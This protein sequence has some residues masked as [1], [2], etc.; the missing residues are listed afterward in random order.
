MKSTKTMK[1]TIISLIKMKSPEI[2]TKMLIGLLSD[3]SDPRKKINALTKKGIIKSVKQG[4]YVIDEDL[5]LRP[6]SKEILANLIYGPS[7][8]SLET[9]LSSYGFIPERVT[10]ITS[11][12]FGR[13]KSF[14]TPVG[15]FNYHHIKES[16]Y[17]CGVQMKEVYQG[18]YCQY[19]APEKALLDFL[20][21]KVS[22][23]AFKNQKEYFKYLIDSYRFDLQ[24]IAEKVSL[25]KLQD[26]AEHYP[27]QNI[28]W[29]ADELTRTLIK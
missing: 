6:Y 1:T 11:I 24:T 14:S 29:F 21:I 9:A 22:K 10:A 19:A 15:D 26:Y 12:C 4:V 17:P 13:G 5:G 20:Y 25:R 2:T 18:A 3:Y 23:G 8:I 27:F 28:R 16:I 7:Y